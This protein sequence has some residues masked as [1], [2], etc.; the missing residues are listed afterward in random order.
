MIVIPTEGAVE[1]LGKTLRVALVT[2]EALSLRLYKNNVAPSPASTV[3]SFTEPTFGGYHRIDLPRAGWGVPEVSGSGALSTWAG[4]PNEW[5]AT[6]SGE[7][8]FGYFLVSPLSGKVQ[9]AERFGVSMP[10]VAGKKLV[11]GLKFSG[12][13]IV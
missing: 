7:T 12:R 11:V 13:G 4:D 3:A 10:V 9:W 6:S 2:D 5:L 8:I 1:L